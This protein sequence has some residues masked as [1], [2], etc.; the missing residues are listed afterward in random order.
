MAPLPAALTPEEQ[1]VA[2]CGLRAEISVKNHAAKAVPSLM[3]P[4][5]EGLLPRVR[6]SWQ[7]FRYLAPNSA[8][9]TAPVGRMPGLVVAAAYFRPVP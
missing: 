9:A 1:A 3:L 7:S 2:C 8:F 6:T 5:G 4:V